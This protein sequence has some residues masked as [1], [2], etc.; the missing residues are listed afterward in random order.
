M[1]VDPGGGSWKIHVVNLHG[2]KLWIPV[3][4]CGGSWWI[5]MMDLSGSM[6]WILVVQSA[7]SFWLPVMDPGCIPV[8]DPDQ[9]QCWILVVVNPDGFSWIQIMDSCVDSWWIHILGPVGPQLWILVDPIGGSCYS[10]MLDP[11]GSG[12]I[13]LMVLLDRSGQSWWIH[14]KIIVSWNNYWAKISVL[15]QYF[16]FFF[17]ESQTSLT[18]LMENSTIFFSK[19]S[20]IKTRWHYYTGCP[21]TSAS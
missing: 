18:P 6:W 17:V 12:W 5:H 16:F 10:H 20:L 9:S 1:L 15:S 11:S 4:T 14:P 8:V 19:P 21:K 13:H 2:S 7:G 3:D